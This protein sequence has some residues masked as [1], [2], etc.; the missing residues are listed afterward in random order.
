[1]RKEDFVMRSQSSEKVGANDEK[2]SA[3]IYIQQP[4]T[5]QKKAR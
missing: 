4:A 2:A 5:K 1:M 3:C